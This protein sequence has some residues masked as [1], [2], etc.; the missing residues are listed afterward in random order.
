MADKSIE[1]KDYQKAVALLGRE[2]R[3]PFIIKTRCGNGNP[4]TLVADPIFFEDNLWKPFP[5]FIWL[6]CPRLKALVADLEQQGFVKYCSQKLINDENF[7]NEYLIGQKE[8]AD[9]RLR[10]AEEKFAKPLPQHIYDILKNTSIA[11][12]HNV[13]G[14]KCLHAH[15]AHY[16]A[17]GNNPIGKEI[18][19]KIGNCDKESNCDS[20]NA[21]G[22]K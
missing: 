9:Y 14:V 2:P 3:S 7:R 12:S 6:V 4:Q 5:S 19:E 13:C 21:G 15:L 11:G 18:I 1:E 17:F 20:E 8:I 16:L 10:L 22:K